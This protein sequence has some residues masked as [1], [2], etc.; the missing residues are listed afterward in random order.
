MIITPKQL[1]HR[2]GCS[3]FHIYKLVRENKIPHFKIGNRII[4]FR[5]EAIDEYERQQVDESN[6]TEVAQAP[7]PSTLFIPPLNSGR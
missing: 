7:M 1:A 2:W 3:V 4:R 6:L 5:T